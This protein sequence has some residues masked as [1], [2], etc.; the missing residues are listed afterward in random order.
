VATVIDR[1]F[2]SDPLVSLAQK[3]NFVGWVYGIDYEHALVMTNDLWKARVNGIPHNCFLIATTFDP[4]KYS[5]TQKIDKE[6]IL[7]RV[8]GSTKMPQDDDMVRTKIDHFQEQEGS[9]EESVNF[10]DITLNQIQFGGL[11]C[12]ILGTFYMYE[13]KLWLGSDIESFSLASRLRVYRPNDKALELI[14]NHIDPIR[15]QAM[16]QDAQDIGLAKPID[17]IPI[18]TVRYTSTDRLHRKEASTTVRV[19]IHPS[20]FLARRTAVLGMTRTGKSNMV[21]QTVTMVKRVADEAGMPIG[22]IIFDIN[23]E[24]ANANQQDRGAIS[25]VYADDTIR[26]RMMP[27]SGFVALLNN[28]YTQLAEGFSLICSEL[29]TNNRVTSDYIRSFVELSFDEPEAA[30]HGAHNRWEKTVAAYQTML[31]K[32]GYRAPQGFHIKFSA[33]QKVKELIN[34][35]ATQNTERGAGFDDPSRGLSPTDAAAW[36]EIAQR[37]NTDENPLPG[38]SKGARFVDDT[39]QNLLNMIAQKNGP[40]GAY[41]SGYKILDVARKYHSEQRQTDVAQEIYQHLKAG[42]IVILDLSVGNPEI[43]ERVSKTI[44]STIFN[45]SMAVF[46]EGQAP[47][48]IVVYI[49][50]AHNLIGKKLELTETWPRLAKEGAKYRV[51]LVYA[52]QEPSSVHPNILSN[53][54]NWFVTHLNNEGELKEISKFYDF[55]D[56]GRSLM[57]AQ[58]VGFARVK[59]LSGPFV[60]PVQIDKFD[61]QA[62]IVRQQAQ[63]K[64]K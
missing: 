38:S 62:E 14:I 21:K 23:G 33:N 55:A 29:R 34:N 63:A 57:R 42:K 13:N 11:N 3:E 49:E 56:F 47:P 6:A 51:A 37:L 26:Y 17:P 46:V 45:N 19:T 7:L 39:L 32:A 18:G 31:Y 10:D 5:D 30:D 48:H 61:P 22:Q 27:T 12:R 40:S 43:R 44:A 9:F 50:E 54:E 36:F 59:T 25:E 2:K 24:Y 28:F 16:L 1:I 35:Y 8:V 64:D 20:D 15:A 60:I 52:T 41:I 53:T 4:D 58:D